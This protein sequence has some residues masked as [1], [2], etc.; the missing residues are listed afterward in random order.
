MVEVGKRRRL[1]RGGH[2]QPQSQ[3]GQPHP[4]WF[5]HTAATASLGAHLQAPS[6]GPDHAVSVGSWGVGLTHP[7]E[8]SRPLWIQA[9]RSSSCGNQ[10]EHYV[11]W[12]WGSFSW[13]GKEKPFLSI[14][15]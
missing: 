8:V 4:L 3:P 2:S 7:G 13:S 12:K 1:L 9:D 15:K 5:Q 11:I 6:P 14:L 10:M